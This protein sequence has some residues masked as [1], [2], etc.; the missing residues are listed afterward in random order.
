MVLGRLALVSSEFVPKQSER[1]RYDSN[2]AVRVRRP[3]VGPAAVKAAPI[4]RLGA[5]SSSASAIL[6][7]YLYLSATQHGSHLATGAQLI[8]VPVGRLGA[9][10]LF[11]SVLFCCRSPLFVRRGL[12]GSAQVSSGRRRS[13]TGRAAADSVFSQRYLIVRPLVVACAA[14]TCVVAPVT[15]TLTPPK[16][17]SSTRQQVAREM[18]LTD[19]ITRQQRSDTAHLLTTTFTRGPPN[20]RIVAGAVSCRPPPL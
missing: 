5:A 4:S 10:R 1:E 19:A 20:G 2:E 9:R 11:C 7:Y 15:P 8:I 3:S 16:L 13:L 17:I 12:S 14:V 18:S 6:H